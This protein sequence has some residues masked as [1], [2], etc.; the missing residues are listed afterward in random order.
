MLR[1][2]FVSFVSVCVV[3]ASLIAQSA[4]PIP[5][6]VGTT[7]ELI[8]T[9]EPA[10][11]DAITS[12][13]LAAFTKS[14]AVFAKAK[15]PVRLYRVV[16]PSVIP[17]KANRPTMASGLV[18]VPDSGAAAMP[19]VSYQHGTVF[20]W[21]S[22]VPSVPEDSMETRL[23]IAQFASRGFVVIGRTTSV[24]AASPRRTAT[25]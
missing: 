24:S 25:W 11:I 15:L 4:G 19:V 10:R 9:W 18:A 2:I 14:D 6:S 5:V 20:G 7:F 3:A 21:S 13:E 22:E 23:A 1:S 8:A 16:Y 17:E 12:K